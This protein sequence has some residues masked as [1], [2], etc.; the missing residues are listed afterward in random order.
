[1]R[2]LTLAAHKL[3]VISELAS[4][5]QGHAGKEYLS[6]IWVFEFYIS[7]LWVLYTIIIA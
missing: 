2:R 7:L 1:M 4:Y 6:G 5:V 3:P